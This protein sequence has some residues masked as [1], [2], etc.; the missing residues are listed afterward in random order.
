[1]LP[2]VLEP[3][4]ESWN[5]D[6]EAPGEEV[7]VGAEEVRQMAPGCGTRDFLAAQGSFESNELVE[8]TE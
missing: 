4:Q 3:G 2:S 1:M 5:W 8:E 6:R 7:V